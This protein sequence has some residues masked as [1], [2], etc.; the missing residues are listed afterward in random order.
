MNLENTGILTLVHTIPSAKPCH[1]HDEANINSTHITVNIPFEPME[2]M[3]KIADTHLMN[4]LLRIHI[5]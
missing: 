3:P 1:F 2:L 5:T 4:V